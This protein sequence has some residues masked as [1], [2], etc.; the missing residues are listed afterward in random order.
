MKGPKKQKCL[1]ILNNRGHYKFE[2]LKNVD[3]L[4]TETNNKTPAIWICLVA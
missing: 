1:Q 3:L 2:R 4:M